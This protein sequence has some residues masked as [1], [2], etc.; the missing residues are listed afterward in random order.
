MADRDEGN[1]QWERKSW[2]FTATDVITTL[3][4]HTAMSVTVDPFGGPTL[5]DVIVTAAD[6]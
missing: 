1:L 4:F 6:E 2:H 5:D 3:E